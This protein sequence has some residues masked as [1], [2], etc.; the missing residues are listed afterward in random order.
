VFPQLSDSGSQSSGS[1]ADDLPPETVMVGRLLYGI[2]GQL[3]GARDVVE[4][5][6]PLE[7][8]AFLSAV[9]VSWLLGLS[10]E[11]VCLAALW[12]LVGVVMGAL[13]CPTTMAADA[14]EEVGGSLQRHISGLHAIGRGGLFVRLLIGPTLVYG[15]SWWLYPPVARLALMLLPFVFGGLKAMASRISL[16]TFLLL[17]A[18]PK[19]VDNSSF[20]REPSTTPRAFRLR[21]PEV[22]PV[23]PRP[24]G[25]PLNLS[26]TAAA[27][28]PNGGHSGPPCDALRRMVDLHLTDGWVPSID[29]AVK[30]ELKAVPWSSTKALRVTAVF[31]CSL[32]AFADFFAKPENTFTIDPLL[33]KKEEIAH[34]DAQ[35]T[36]VY[37]AYKSPVFGVTRRD[38]V[39]Q[40]SKMFLTPDEASSLGLPAR[41]TFVEA[42]TSCEHPARPPFPDYVRSKTFFSGYVAQEAG[43]RR[44]AVVNVASVSPEGW[45]PAKVVDVVAA[46]VVAKVEKLQR[47]LQE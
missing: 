15:A 29:G 33:E 13:N 37:C 25:A 39:L 24:C 43:P 18:C 40:Y 26:L 7:S 36:V 16:R 17:P 22:H 4:W 8:A 6:N 1:H 31:E 44:L 38:A 32:E 34:L 9:A 45:I 10:F 21:T 28:I 23:T 20:P 14:L 47:V 42:C 19:A 41:R 3:E 35:T 30:L 2:V 11:C 46:K 5:A 27:P 12:A